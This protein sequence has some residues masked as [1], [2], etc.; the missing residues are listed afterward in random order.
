VF[1]PRKRAVQ[2][3]R[4]IY[5]DSG[6]TVCIISGSFVRLLVMPVLAFL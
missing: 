3:A 6:R 1:V 4:Y 2:S 5:T